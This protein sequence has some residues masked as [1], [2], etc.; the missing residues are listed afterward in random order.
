MLCDN[1]ERWDGDGVGGPVCICGAV[2]QQKL[3]QHYKAIILQLKNKE[4]YDSLI[5]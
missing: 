4:V 3:A 2:V 5:H 1:L